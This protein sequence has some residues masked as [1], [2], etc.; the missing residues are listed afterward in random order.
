MRKSPSAVSDN[1][2]LKSNLFK[3]LEGTEKQVMFKR[4]V[5]QRASL[6]LLMQTPFTNPVGVQ[7]TYK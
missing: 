3:S 1:L 4:I 7:G 5:K 6:V 2:L